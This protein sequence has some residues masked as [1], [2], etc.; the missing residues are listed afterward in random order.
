MTMTPKTQTEQTGIALITGAAQRI[1]KA[2]TEHLAAK[3]WD[4]AI[5]FNRSSDE[6]TALA[7]ELS[8]QYPRQRFMT[9]RADLLLDHETEDLLPAVI[10]AM[11]KPQL[12]INN[13]SVFDSGKL[14][15]TATSFFD[16]QITV[17][18]KAPFI[19]LREFINRCGK[20]LVI[21][22]AD[23][24]ISGNSESYA[25]YTLAKKSLWELTKMAAAAYGPSIRVNAV[26]PGLT[27]PPEG[28][29]EEYL[30]KLAARIPMKR[31]GG[32][33][34]V[35]DSLDYLLKNEYLTGELLHCDG[36]QHLL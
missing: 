3:G 31:P 11:G 23:T 35:L 17:N 28:K 10:E 12:L 24:R 25:A 32:I 19:L 8:R 36:G 21:N 29:D 27:L 22:I 33:H 15:E 6:A 1:G 9:F 4:A 30:H 16:R 26:A 7:T 13:A 2:M 14:S 34:P 18:L 20:G 5:H